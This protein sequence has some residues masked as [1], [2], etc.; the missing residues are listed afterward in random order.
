MV[1][2]WF[3]FNIAPFDAYTQ[4]Q[5]FLSHLDPIFAISINARLKCL[6]DVYIIGESKFQPNIAKINNLILW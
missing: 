2:Y 6:F 4:C 3:F 5:F 1:S